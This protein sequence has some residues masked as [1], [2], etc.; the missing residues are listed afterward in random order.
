MLRDVQLPFTPT[1]LDCVQWSPEGDLAVVTDDAVHIV[2]RMG[3][4]KDIAHESPP[5]INVLAGSKALVPR[6]QGQCRRLPRRDITS[7]AFRQ[8][9]CRRQLRH[10][11]LSP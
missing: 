11:R 9:N 7:L 2:V 8:A 1:T 10:V 6:P 3:K 4:E 5:L